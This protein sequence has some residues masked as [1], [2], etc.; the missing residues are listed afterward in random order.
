MSFDEE[1]R[2]L[3][4]ET[5]AQQNPGMRLNQSGGN[6]ADLSVPEADLGLVGKNAYELYHR[7]ANDGDHARASTFE[8]AIALTN[9]NFRTGPALTTVHD[10]WRSQLKT[11]LDACANISN[12]LDSTVAAHRK[13]E[14]DIAV[15]MSVS[16]ISQYLK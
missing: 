10:T 9:D 15:S 12:H 13:D 6:D 1:W 4:A 11:L 2:R 5:A 8:A 7:L 14:A 3:K 16:K